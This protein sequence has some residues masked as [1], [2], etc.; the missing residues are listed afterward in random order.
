MISYEQLLEELKKH[1]GE[2]LSGENIARRLNLSR[3]AIWKAINRLKSDGYIID[4]MPNKGYRLSKSNDI[5]S[6]SEIASYVDLPLD[7]EIRKLVTST[8]TVAKEYAVNGCAEGKVIISEEQSEGKGR[9]GRAF[10]SPKDNGLYM[11]VVLRPKIDPADALLITTAS[12]VAVAE[13]IEELTAQSAQI[14]WVNDIYCG[15]KKVCGI[16]TEAS[17]DLESRRLDY[18]VLGIGVNIKIPQEGFPKNLKAIAG[19]I[20][21]EQTDL[22]D[23]RNR[24]AGT[25]LRNFFR[26]YPCLEQKNYLQDYKKRSMLLGME[27]VILGQTEELATA[28]DIDENC[29]LIALTHSGETKVL[30]SGE[31]SVRL[32]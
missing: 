15:G 30:S 2:Y 16:L 24:L 17:F 32:S 18:A 10:Y 12:A 14:K 20:S 26:Y 23:M 8:N 1:S 27:I 6:A 21:D 3:N 13:A 19:A 28:I 29:Q 7:I 22:G 5:L 25:I 11:S 4:A 9:K 31:V